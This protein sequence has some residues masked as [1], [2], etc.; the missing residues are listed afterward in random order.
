MAHILFVSLRTGDMGPDVAQAELGDVLA[1]S[2]L[3]ASDVEMRV[4]A[5]TE[6]A[7]G[8]LDGFDG[9]IVGGSS[10]NV[11]APEYSPWQRHVHA[12]LSELVTSP[13]PVFLVCFGFSWLSAELGGTVGH[14]APEVS[15]PTDVTLTAAAEGD[16][17]L[18]GYPASFAA[19][20]GHT[21]N[22]EIVPPELEVLATGPTGAAQLVR[23][24]SVVWASQFHAEMD[25]A[26]MKARMDFY[27]DYGYFPLSEYD[28]IVAALP[29]V[30]VSW[31]N[32]LL[33]RFVAVCDELS[34]RR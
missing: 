19:F 2:G 18:H 7:I 30:D 27:Y 34:P 11:T 10:L 15:G 12:Q 31:A 3:N 21:E 20:T 29:A 25:A 16:R 6:T 9:V 22:P 5:D 24:G 17:L 26:A 28:T 8:S 14:S 13:V 1:A 33:R 32:E 4:I 23:Y